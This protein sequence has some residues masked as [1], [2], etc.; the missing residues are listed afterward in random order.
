MMT[1]YCILAAFVFKYTN[2]N[3]LCQPYAKRKSTDQRGLTSIRKIGKYK[4]IRNNKSNKEGK[5]LYSVFTHKT[6]LNEF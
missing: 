3:D 4:L 1:K 5:I 6:L 2:I